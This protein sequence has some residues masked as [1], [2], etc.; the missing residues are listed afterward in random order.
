METLE[1]L[2]VSN[3]TLNVFQFISYAHII[4]KYIIFIILFIVLISYSVFHN[5]NTIT[6]F[7]KQPK[8]KT[9]DNNIKDY[10]TTINHQHSHTLRSR[11]HQAIDLDP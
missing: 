7:F 11:I 6:L 8:E 1:G 5:L 9:T 4:M 2:H 10:I 3:T